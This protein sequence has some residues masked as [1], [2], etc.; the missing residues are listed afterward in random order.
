MSESYSLGI[1]LCLKKKGRHTLAVLVA[2]IAALSGCGVLN[3]PTVNPSPTVTLTP[4]P[5]A[6]LPTLT[7]T[8]APTTAPAT[9]PAPTATLT[10]SP[11][12]ARP[13]PTSSPQSSPPSAT[14]TP[15]S[16][17]GNDPVI[18]FFTASPSEIDPGGSVLLSWKASADTITLYPLNPAG[19]LASQGTSLS[20]EGSTTVTTDSSVR[21]SVSYM[22]FATTGGKS[23]NASVQIAVR[24]PDSWFFG[25]PPAI[26]PSSSAILS[27]A[28]TEHFEHGWMLWIS[29][30][31]TI[32]VLYDD[33]IS[34]PRWSSFPN[35]WQ[36]N[37]PD[38]DPSIVPPPGLYQPQRGFGL[39]WREESAGQPY[40]PRSRLGWATEIE[41][42]F[43]SS[44]QCD[45]AY[46]YGSCYLKGPSGE[47]IW[48][49][50]ELSGWQVWTGPS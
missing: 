18:A 48:L 10:Q 49:K 11:T 14:I 42:P 28:A 29:Q 22:L 44:F 41:S 40:S 8:P 37:M 4:G 31:Q 30:T 19:Q 7:L 32:F 3:P 50:P 34:S 12:A 35:T 5:G 27:Q 38:S 23:V 26:C 25:N 1:P 13:R 39:V 20:P 15:G 47:T 6:T 16:P 21:N 46:K 2:L 45:S 36:S 24:C 9:S 33:L 43:T 17:S